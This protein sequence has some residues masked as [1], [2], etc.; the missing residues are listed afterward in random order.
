MSLM[1]HLFALLYDKHFKH[2]N[3]IANILFPYFEERCDG[4]LYWSSTLLRPVHLCVALKTKWKQP[5]SL[6]V[7][8][9]RN[10]M[11]KSCRPGWLASS[12]AWPAH[13]AQAVPLQI[14]AAIPGS[15]WSVYSLCHGAEH[16]VIQLFL[17]HIN[18]CLLDLCAIMKCSLG[19]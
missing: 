9:S 13:I 3:Y 7:M 8:F 1:F 14:H 15:H 6:C 16:K 2:L 17:K 10:D 18:V 4:L 5:H 12:R 11:Q 19:L